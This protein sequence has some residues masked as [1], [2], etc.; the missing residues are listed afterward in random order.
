[1]TI[2]IRDYLTRD[3]MNQGEIDF[4]AQGLRSLHTDFINNDQTQGFRVT[5]VD[6]LDDPVNDPSEVAKRAQ[7]KAD[8]VRRNELRTK[9]NITLPEMREL[10][11][12]SL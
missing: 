5:F 4:N 3:L 10:L 7:Q 8:D 9:P 12:L 1:M 11:L 2:E 6:G